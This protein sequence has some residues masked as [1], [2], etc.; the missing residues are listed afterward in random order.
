VKLEFPWTD[1]ELA[2]CGRDEGLETERGGQCA[3]CSRS[4]RFWSA[5]AKT[6]RHRAC[7][8]MH[9]MKEERGGLMPAPVQARSVLER[10][11]IN[12]YEGLGFTGRTAVTVLYAPPTFAWLCRHFKNAV[13]SWATDQLLNTDD[14]HDALKTVRHMDKTKAGVVGFIADSYAAAGGK[15]AALRV[16]QQAPHPR[17]VEKRKRLMSEVRAAEFR[18]AQLNKE[19]VDAKS[20]V[21]AAVADLSEHR[22]A[23]GTLGLCPRCGE[24]ANW[25]ASAYR[26]EKCG[27]ESELD[28]PSG[29]RPGMENLKKKGAKRRGKR[30]KQRKP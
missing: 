16:G 9:L 25:K 24:P 8:T 20:A 11:E 19:L 14:F 7:V 10:H 6:I 21:N 23:H 28:K 13:A 27:S 30:N 22:T 5:H 18:V 1:E 4:Y 12:Y 29:W 3:V 15:N 17:S 2:F 26:C